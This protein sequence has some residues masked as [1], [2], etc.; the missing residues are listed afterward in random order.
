M[1]GNC[2]TSGKPW[3][4]FTKGRSGLNIGKDSNSNWTFIVLNLVL[5]KG[6]SKAQQHL[7]SQPISVT[8][9]RKEVEHTESAMR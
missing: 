7:D 1:G 4:R 8:R 6:D 3:L 5:T 9:D 2:I